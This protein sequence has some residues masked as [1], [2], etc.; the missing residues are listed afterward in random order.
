MLSG[1]PGGHAPADPPD[2]GG[3]GEGPGACQ[4]E[5]LLVVAEAALESASPL[6]GDGSSQFPSMGP[7]LAVP[8]L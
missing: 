4:A 8:A 6:L 5:V 7:V 1:G 2:L 3:P